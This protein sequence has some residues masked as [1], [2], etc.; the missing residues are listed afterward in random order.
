MGALITGLLCGLLFAL[1]ALFRQRKEIV[2]FLAEH[3]NCAASAKLADYDYDEHSNL[4]TCQ[5]TY[6]YKSKDYTYLKMFFGEPPPQSI[7][8]MWKRST[9]NE[10]IPYDEVEQNNK[11]ILFT[12]LAGLAGGLMLGIAGP[13]ATLIL[14]AVLYVL[15]AFI[16]IRLVII[17]ILF[18]S[19]FAYLFG[20]MWAMNNVPGLAYFEADWEIEQYDEFVAQLS[21]L[22]EMSEVAIC[23]LYLDIR[24]L[25]RDITEAKELR[26]VPIFGQFANRYLAEL[27]PIEWPQE[28]IRY[29][30]TE[31]QDEIYERRYHE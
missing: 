31:V 5:Y 30:L 21:L 18:V 7:H 14:L 10:P 12:G 26:E 8:I 19:L 15:W 2:I 17:P 6:S 16:D 22:D 9:P 23:D 4:Y 28:Y 24:W 3:R 1:G 27:E 25:N 29:S 20:N 13:Q 11:T